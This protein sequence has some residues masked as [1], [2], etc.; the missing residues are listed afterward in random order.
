MSLLVHGR[1]HTSQ[2]YTVPSSS[3]GVLGRSRLFFGGGISSPSGLILW[4]LV[5]SS[6]KS[7]SS[8]DCTFTKNIIGCRKQALKTMVFFILK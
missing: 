6:G 2:K 1:L 4:G 8:N 3:T 5:L 7:S